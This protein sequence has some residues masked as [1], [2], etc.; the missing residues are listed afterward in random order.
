MSA[1]THSLDES[2]RWGAPTAIDSPLAFHTI[3][4]LIAAAYLDLP[5]LPDPRPSS[6]HQTKLRESITRGAPTAIDS[7]PALHTLLLPSPAYPHTHHQTSPVPT[8]LFS[9]V[10]YTWN[11]NEIFKQIRSDVLFYV[12]TCTYSATLM[13]F[14]IYNCQMALDK[15]KCASSLASTTICNF[16]QGV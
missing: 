11:G 7:P 10:S 13:Q 4:L 15:C 14:T 8:H 16:S 6:R 2:I 1:Q 3:L 5:T 9:N 12:H